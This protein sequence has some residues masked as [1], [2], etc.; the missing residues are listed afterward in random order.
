[1]SAFFE[2]AR[3][4]YVLLGLLCRHAVWKKLKQLKNE[5]YRTHCVVLGKINNSTEIKRIPLL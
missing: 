3:K 5:N 4:A 1:M 2:H